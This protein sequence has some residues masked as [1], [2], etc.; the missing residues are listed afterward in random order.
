ML[1]A[2]AVK[3]KNVFLR[4]IDFFSRDCCPCRFWRKNVAGSI[5]CNRAAKFLWW[6]PRLLSR[7]CRS[8]ACPTAHRGRR[9]RLPVK[10][11]AAEHSSENALRRHGDPKHPPDSSSAALNDRPEKLLQ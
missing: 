7:S 4:V 5:S 11:K 6:E 10:A 3:A 9:D 8:T 2:M 1:M